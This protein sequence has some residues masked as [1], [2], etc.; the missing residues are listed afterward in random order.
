MEAYQDKLKEEAW[1]KVSETVGEPVEVAGQGVGVTFCYGDSPCI[2]TSVQLVR[3][4]CPGQILP[5]SSIGICS[6]S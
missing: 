2:K 4:L 5:R 1:R 6:S 3:V